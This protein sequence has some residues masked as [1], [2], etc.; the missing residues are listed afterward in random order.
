MKYH[1]VTFS[2]TTRSIAY[3]DG[4]E[5]ARLKESGRKYPDMIAINACKDVSENH[6]NIEVIPLPIAWSRAQ[7]WEF[8]EASIAR[9]QELLKRWQKIPSSNPHKGKKTA[10]SA[11]RK[12]TPG[13]AIQHKYTARIKLPHHKNAVATEFWSTSDARALA[14]ANGLMLKKM[15]KGA[16]CIGLKQTAQTRRVKKK[17]KK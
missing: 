11:S 2:P 12:K 1:L 15:P 13:T 6:N 17:A 16:K 5:F 8:M 4:V 9:R 3:F 7:S 10:R 14:Y